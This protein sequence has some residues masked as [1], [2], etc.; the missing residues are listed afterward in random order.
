MLIL[1]VDSL[2]TE[3]S[4]AYF[5]IVWGIWLRHCLNGRQ[6]EYKLVWPSMFTLPEVDKIDKSEERQ[7]IIDGIQNGRVKK[8]Q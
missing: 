2:L 3:V 4:G 6:D 7:S 1:I 8:S 5:Y